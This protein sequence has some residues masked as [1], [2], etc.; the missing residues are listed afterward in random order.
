MFNFGDSFGSF[1]AR[2][3]FGDLARGKAKG[4]AKGKSRKA[5]GRSPAARR[6][7]CKTITFKRKSKGGK[8]LPRSQ[9][10]TIQR[11]E[12]KKLKAT[13][14]RQCRRG[15]KGPQ[16]HLFVRCPRTAG[17]RRAA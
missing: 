3:S 10:V 8:L 13:N 7:G 6:A 4:K 14:R 2:R 11:C 16:A 15:G 12:S 17:A 5:K 1:G 9:W